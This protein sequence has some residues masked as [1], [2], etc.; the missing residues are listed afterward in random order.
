M[1]LNYSSLMAHS[2]YIPYI[3]GFMSYLVSMLGWGFGKALHLVKS[4]Q[5]ERQSRR[6]TMETAK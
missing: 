4:K 6:G 3:V 5:R 2:L 1:G